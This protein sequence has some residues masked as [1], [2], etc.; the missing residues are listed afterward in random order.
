MIQIEQLREVMNKVSAEKGEFIL[1][2]LFLR[3]EDTD[4]WDLVISAPWLEEGKLRGLGEFVKRM[5]AIIGEEELLTLSRIVTLN[6]DDPSLKAILKDV[7][8][9]NDLVVMQGSNLF[10][11]PIKEAY[12]LRAKRPLKSSSEAA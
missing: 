3:E 9:D 1:F 4:K 7:Q 8:V 12:I 10:G 11:L 5:A 6:Q 2:G